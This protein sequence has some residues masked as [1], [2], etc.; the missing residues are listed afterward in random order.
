M[1]THCLPAASAVKLGSGLARRTR[2][3]RAPGAWA[4]CALILL[5]PASRAQFVYTMDYVDSC[6]FQQDRGVPAARQRLD[7][8]LS[9]YLDELDRACKLS[10]AQKKK[11]QLAGRGDIKHFFDRYEH[12][13]RNFK[14]FN[15]NQ[16]DFQEVWQKLWQEVSPLQT[17]LQSG[18]FEE[19]SLFLKSI[20]NTLTPSQRKGYDAMEN[21]RRE[22]NWRIT[23]AQAIETLD[24]SMRLT[25]AQRRLLSDL[26]TKETKPPKRNTVNYY[27]QYYLFWQLDKVPHERFRPKFDAIQLKFL[28][29]QLQQARNVARSM[30]RNK[31]WPGNEATDD[32]D[33]AVKGKRAIMLKK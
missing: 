12:V 2:L 14:P 5:A 29:A 27:E 3:C 20:S 15:Q 6:I 26:M 10:D 1:I 30:Q 17:S 21:E 4:I 28:D 16:P 18:L 9:I 11:L 19:E 23:I 8:H 25:N 13:K 31:Q 24:R 7:S 33:N 22:F 32:D